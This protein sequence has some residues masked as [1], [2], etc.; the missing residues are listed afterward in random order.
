[1]QAAELS[2]IAAQEHGH[3]GESLPDEARNFSTETG[4]NDDQDDEEEHTEDSD[5]ELE[6]SYE[7]HTPTAELGPLGERDEGS[8]GQQDVSRLHYARRLTATDSLSPVEY[9]IDNLK[10]RLAEAQ[11]F[12]AT[13]EAEVNR[14]RSILEE[15][16]N[17]KHK[18]EDL[19][20]ELE[21]HSQ[22]LK[23]AEECQ[24]N[25]K[26]AVTDLQ[27]RLSKNDFEYFNHFFY[28]FPRFFANFFSW[29]I[30]K[31]TAQ[32]S[33]LCRRKTSLQ[34]KVLAMPS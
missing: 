30:Q 7:P 10:L 28:F 25:A 11:Q 8:K 6:E 3:N 26:K 20:R 13:A 1:M 23:T 24:R 4:L 22:Q 33:F 5:D 32:F 17:E 12:S 31:N 19:V 9:D 29:K 2:Q 16:E 27:V 34:N 15:Y 21:R 18:S 14:L